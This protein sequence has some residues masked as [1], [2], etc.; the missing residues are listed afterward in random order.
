MELIVH[1]SNGDKKSIYVI[2]EY[3]KVST[4]KNEI[5][6]QF[7]VDFEKQRLYFNFSTSSD[8]YYFD[9]SKLIKIG[10]VNFS[11]VKVRENCKNIYCFFLI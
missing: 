10:T 9:E 8:L 7:D 1:L 5:T 6:N 2:D 4:L 11:V 3:A